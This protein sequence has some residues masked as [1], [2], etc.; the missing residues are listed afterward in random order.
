MLYYSNIAV[1]PLNKKAATFIV[2]ARGLFLL[3]FSSLLLCDFL[4]SSFFL[5]HLSKFLGEINNRADHSKSLYYIIAHSK[6]LCQEKKVEN[7]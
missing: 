4:F 7:F 2:T 6:E 1:K 5:C 3:F